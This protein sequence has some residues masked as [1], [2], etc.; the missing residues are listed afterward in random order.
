MK[1][2]LLVIL[3][4]QS[5]GLFA[6]MEYQLTPEEKAYFYHVVRKSPIIENEIGPYVQYIGTPVRFM[7]KELDH[8][9]I[10][11]MIIA[12]PSLI[13]FHNSELMK[14]SRGIITEVCNKV[15]LLELNQ[16]IAAKG[17]NESEFAVFKDQFTTFETYLNEQLPAAAYKPMNGEK[18]INSKLFAVI[19]PALNYQDKAGML[20]SFPF[21]SPEEQLQ[22]NN[23]I[24]YAITQYVAFKTS[25]FLGAIVSDYSSTTNYLICAGDGSESSGEATDREKDEN[26][27]WTKGLP[28]A[29]GFFPYQSTLLPEKKRDKKSIQAETFP[30]IDLVTPGEYMQSVIHFDVWAYNPKAQTT[31]IIER[32]GLT[33][34]LFGNAEDRFLSPDSNFVEDGKTFQKTIN[35]LEQVKIKELFDKIYGKKGFDEQIKDAKERKDDVELLINKKEHNYS[36]MTQRPITTSD[37]APRSVKKRKKKA[38]LGTSAGKSSNKTPETITYS[39]KPKRIDKQTDIVSLN[40]EYQFLKQLIADLERQKQESIDLMARYQLRLDVYKTQFG[41][42]WSKYKVVNGLYVFQDSSTFNILTQDFTFKA[43]TAKTPFEVRI[44]AIPLES[45]SDETEEVKLHMSYSKL[46][47][48]YDARIQFVVDNLSK[49]ATIPEFQIGENVIDSTAAKLFI[50][51][52]LDKKFKFTVTGYGHGMSKWNGYRAV[53]CDFTEININETTEDKAKLRSLYTY[54]TLRENASIE[55]HVA[56]DASSP[57]GINITPEMQAYLTKNKLSENDYLTLLQLKQA[58]VAYQA[59]LIAF[60]KQNS[61]ASEAKKIESKIKKGFSTVTV[62]SG[63]TL[64]KLKDIK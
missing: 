2:F 54:L 38:N 12:D 37:K 64:V 11:R 28:K 20:A 58:L 13:V 48:N 62:Y 56:T 35:N 23:A 27:R 33:Y 8:D 51:K 10:E 41:R 1:H 44:L 24:D 60:V 42:T 53:K 29:V 25:L 49:E 5:V 52:A 4:F 40:Q 39:Q 21:L 14:S 57:E 22:T 55:I 9:S 43:D 63:K 7:N 16:I 46:N 34:P 32:N 6:Q 19:N 50:V 18:V 61:T 59:E 17:K 26:N 3:F 15:A 36:D 31:V 47:R 45:L 30:V